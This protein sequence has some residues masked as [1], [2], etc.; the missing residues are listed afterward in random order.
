MKP[1]FSLVVPIYSPLPFQRAMTEFCLKTMRYHADHDYELI[2]VE[3]GGEHWRPEKHTDPAMRID[4]Y[5]NFPERTGN[6]VAEVNAGAD[7][8]TCDLIGH[9]GNDLVMPQ[10]WDTALLEP[11][12]KYA[13]CGMSGL[14]GIEP[15]AAPVGPADPMPKIVESYYAPLML[16]D[17]KWRFDAS[18][19]RGWY[20]DNDLLMRIYKAGLRSYR[21]C[22]VQMLH[23]NHMTGKF[24]PEEY[25]RAHRAA[26]KMFHDRWGD[27]PHLMYAMVRSGGVMWGREHEALMRPIQQQPIRR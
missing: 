15:G 6:I 22:S 7:L 13:D 11:F 20:S 25:Q 12:K 17:K 10:G 9:T 26:E 5:L 18:Y 2:V 1:A 8:A 24:E 19:P 4:K 14:S 23:L 21:N 3:A 16:A 27:S